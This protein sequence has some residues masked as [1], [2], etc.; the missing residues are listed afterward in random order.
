MSLDEA[1]YISDKKKKSV[2][3]L[4]CVKFWIF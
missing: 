3:I 4:I 1:L 2:T